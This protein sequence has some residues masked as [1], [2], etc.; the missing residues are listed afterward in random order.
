MAYGRAP[1]A[2]RTGDGPGPGPGLAE[3]RVFG[4]VALDL[5]AAAGL[6]TVHGE[7][8]PTAVL[9]RAPDA[10]PAGSV[11]IGTRDAAAL[12]LTVDGHPGH[13]TP[14]KGRPAR[15]S[16]RVDV[17]YGGVLYRLLPDSP[18]GSRLVKDGRR[19]ADFSSDGGGHVWADWHPDVAP[20]LREDAAVGYALAAAF[21][22]GAEPSWRLL[23]RA[24]AGLVR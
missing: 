22:T 15:R 10:V 18:G 17:I 16:H 7:R 1:A 12:R 14:G 5:D 13:I 24:V 20:P 21:G 8:V 19:I 9:R 4:R 6:L 2:G 3:D 23:V 11:P